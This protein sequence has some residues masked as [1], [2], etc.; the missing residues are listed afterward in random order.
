MKNQK[1]KDALNEYHLNSF[2]HSLSFKTFSFLCLLSCGLKLSMSR[3]S[4]TKESGKNK[5]NNS[6]EFSINYWVIVDRNKF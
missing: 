3:Y 2:T 6:N 4:K 1:K 5:Q